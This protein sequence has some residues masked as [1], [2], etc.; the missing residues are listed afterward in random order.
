VF[1]EDRLATMAKQAVLR[2]WPVPLS[3]ATLAAIEVLAR[4]NM[5]TGATRL[6][7]LRHELWDSDGERWIE[8][9]PGLYRFNEHS[10]GDL[11]SVA[12]IAKKYGISRIEVIWP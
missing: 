9:E 5:L 10:H 8:V 12:E 6:E 1:D 4:L 7:I 2:Q 3:D 11:L